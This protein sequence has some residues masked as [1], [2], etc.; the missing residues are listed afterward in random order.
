MGVSK[1]GGIQIYGGVQTYGASKHI[2]IQT[3][4]GHMNMGV[5]GHTLSLTTPMTA[6][7][8]GKHFMK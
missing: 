5:Y 1:L 2:G 8:V 6:S 4:K 7:K 3:Y